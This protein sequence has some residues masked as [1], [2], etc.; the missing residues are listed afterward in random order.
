MPDTLQHPGHRSLGIGHTGNPSDHEHS[1]HRSQLVRPDTVDHLS[2]L[3]NC[4]LLELRSELEH[5]S[6]SLEPDII[7]MFLVHLGGIIAHIVQLFPF[8][9]LTQVNTF[10]WDFEVL[11]R[12]MIRILSYAEI[13]SFAALNCLQSGNMDSR[14]FME[15]LNPCL[16]HSWTPC[17]LPLYRL[18][19]YNR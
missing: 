4:T 3:L 14:V 2:I 18:S 11:S 13:F 15:P 16:W 1:V 6:A 19:A 7:L 10:R 5:G 8:D 12:D 9:M 17:P